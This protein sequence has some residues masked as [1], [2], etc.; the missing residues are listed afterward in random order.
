[1]RAAFNIALYY[2][3]NDKLEEAEKWAT[4]AQTL[5]QKVD[6]VNLEDTLIDLSRIPNYYLATLYV[7]ELKE[8][9]EGMAKLEGQMS[10]FND[11]F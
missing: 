9:T 11:D 5:A 10:R 7:N 4:V 6:K 1:M 3:M 8:R 2:E